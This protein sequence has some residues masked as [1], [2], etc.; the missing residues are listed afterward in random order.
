MPKIPLEVESKWSK[1]D[2]ILKNIANTN[3]DRLAQVLLKK[4]DS[5]K[6]VVKNLL[7]KNYQVSDRMGEMMKERE[8]IREWSRLIEQLIS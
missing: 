3:S 7:Q 5:D 6:N 2:K 8:V 4:T 1:V